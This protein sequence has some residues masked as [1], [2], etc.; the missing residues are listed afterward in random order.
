MP[1]CYGVEP[2]ATWDQQE[3]RSVGEFLGDIFNGET[4]TE[5]RSELAA[6]RL[7]QYC[8]NTPSCPIVKTMKLQGLI[9]PSFD[10]AG[11]AAPKSG[12][13]PMVTLESLKA[14]VTTEVQPRAA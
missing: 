4:L 1:C 3:D 14:T 6:G 11:I 9:D 12:P 8:L 2:L 13:L 5:I 7:A 10:M